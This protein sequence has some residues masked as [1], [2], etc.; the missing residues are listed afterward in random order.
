M[1][2]FSKIIAVYSISVNSNLVVRQLTTRKRSPLLLCSFNQFKNGDS[3]RERAV[4]EVV[5]VKAVQKRYALIQRFL[6]HHR[7]GR[8]RTRLSE[9][10]VFTSFAPLPS[11]SKVDSTCQ[12]DW[13]VE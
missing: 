7:T 10:I 9:D 6:M 2:L 12:D 1:H 4:V 13:L 3:F 5:S 11:S 8:M